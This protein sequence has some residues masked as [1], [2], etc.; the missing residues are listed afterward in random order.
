MISNKKL[1]LFEIVEKDLANIKG[2]DSE[3]GTN[4][5]CDLCC[6]ACGGGE[7]THQQSFSTISSSS[8]TISSIVTPTT[9]D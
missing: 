7:I 4:C 5:T 2:G 9:T 8:S 1:K 6:C 3:G